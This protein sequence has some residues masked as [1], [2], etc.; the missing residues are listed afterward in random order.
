MVPDGPSWQVQGSHRKH[1]NNPWLHFVNPPANVRA[2]LPQG[3]CSDWLR[4]S[5]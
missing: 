3:A 2:C 1:P 5:K 4:V